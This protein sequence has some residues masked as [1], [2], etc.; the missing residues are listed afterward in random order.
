MKGW[1]LAIRYH[2]VQMKSYVVLILFVLTCTGCFK[3]RRSDKAGDKMQDFVISIS[4][5][6]RSIDSDFVIIPQNGIELAFSNLDASEGFNA[7]YMAAIDAF[8]VEELFY[9]GVYALDNERLNMLTQLKATKQ[10]MVSE[11]VSDNSVAAD[12]YARNYQEGF[13]CFTRLANNYDYLYIP[14]SVPHENANNITHLNEAQN[15]LYIISTNAF[16]NK[17]EMINAISTTNYDVI[18]MDLFFDDDA[19]TSSEISALKMKAN[20][21][22]RLL[23]SYVSVGSAEKYRYYWKKGW[24]LH[25][26]LW[27]K[28]KY[29]GYKDEFWVKFWKKEWQDIIYGNDDS[30]IKKI[31]DAGFDG[32]YLD[33]VEAYYF[34]YHK[35]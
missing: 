15:F 33:N 23:I 17:Q 11:F 34:L 14:D 26:P 9:N 10:V 24:G 12:A 20:G 32:A 8:G 6:A 1:S 27:L 2:C 18:L 25:H 35:D 21:G 28:K 16:Q 29:D 7:S 5:Y 4:N 13:I 19:F 30:Y 22:Q 3:E 31:I